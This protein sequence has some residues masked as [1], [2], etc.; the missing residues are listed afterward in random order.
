M[1]YQILIYNN[2]ECAEAWEER[3]DEFQAAHDAVQAELT[4]SGELVD[5]NE[6]ATDDARIVRVDRRTTRV[7]VTDGPFAESKEWVGGFY[8]VD[9]ASPE[10]AIEI[11]ARFVEAEYSP[12]EVRRVVHLEEA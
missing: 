1:R 2:A 11:A 4:A 10:R 8:L 9:V 12:V 6:W 3:A 7:D 5:S